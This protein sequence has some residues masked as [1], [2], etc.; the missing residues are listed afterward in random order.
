MTSN[1]RLSR[2]TLKLLEYLNISVYFVKNKLELLNIQ[3]AFA[4]VDIIL[5]YCFGIIVPSDIYL[6]APCFNIH[7]GDLKTN[8][9]PYPCVWD[10]LLGHQSSSSTLHR[11]ISKEIDTGEVISTYSINVLDGDNLSSIINRLDEGVKYHLD[12][13]SNYSSDKEYMIVSDGE[14]RSKVK[15]EDVTIADS[16]SISD[17]KRKIN[18]QSLYGGAFLRYRDCLFRVSEVSEIKRGKND[19][20]L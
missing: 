4:G 20:F 19:S 3:E 12:C 16:D 1:D 18:A 17:I 13:L 2:S 14:Y 11:I 15:K 5:I 8:R 6:N 9:G 7:R 10:I